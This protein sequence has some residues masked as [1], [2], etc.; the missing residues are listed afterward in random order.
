MT[1]L[2]ELRETPFEKRDDEWESQF[3]QALLS[4]Q[5]KVIKDQPQKGPDS[6]PYLMVETAD[7]EAEPIA[8]VLE[9]LSARGIGMAVN[10]NQEFPDC[11]LT[12]G[13]VWNFRQ[14]GRFISEAE[15][16]IKSGVVNY[17]SGQKVHAGEPAEEYL[18]E[19]VRKILRDFFRDQGVFLPR[20]LVMS[21]DQKNYDL[22]F[23]LES[24]GNPPKSEHMGILEALGWFFPLHYSLMLAS[25]EGLPKFVAL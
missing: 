8:R 7:A 24:L 12:Y 25:E 16:K 23:S 21:A 22:I 3:H 18:P 2:E 5:V 13:M 11:I 9:W 14:T 20:I 15:G 4:S 10:P 19:Y 6:W 17:E 1:K